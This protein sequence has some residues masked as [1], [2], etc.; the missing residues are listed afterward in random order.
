M[1]NDFGHLLIM[2]VD[3]IF[4]KVIQLHGSG[5]CLVV[6]ITLFCIL[7]WLTSSGW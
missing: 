2:L 6:E 4:L 3:F 1:G 5:I 7:F